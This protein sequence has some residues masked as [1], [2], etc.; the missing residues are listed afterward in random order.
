M[1][2]AMN[3]GNRRP[4]S[5]PPAE[6]QNAAGTALPP[7]S[8]EAERAIL[9]AVLN[10]PD[11]YSSLLGRVRLAEEHFFIDIHR[12]IF[13]CMAQLDEKGLSPDL[14]TI[15]ESIHLL[16][17]QPPSACVDFLLG[18]QTSAP[19]AQNIEHYAHLIR[20]KFYLRRVISAC[21]QT[22]RFRPIH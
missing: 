13:R 5:L 12:K 1:D 14:I 8:A 18:L 7:H 3:T 11:L 9:G 20:N 15:G 17:K 4:P 2:E 21:Q 19:L 22:V 6:D 10:Q 16:T